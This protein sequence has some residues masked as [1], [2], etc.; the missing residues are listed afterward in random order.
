MRHKVYSW[1]VRLISILGPIWGTFVL[2]MTILLVKSKARGEVIQIKLKKVVAAL[3]GF[4][5]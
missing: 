5:R 1:L 3:H 4:S 2:L